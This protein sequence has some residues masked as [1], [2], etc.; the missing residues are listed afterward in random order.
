MTE[1]IAHKRRGLRSRPFDGEG[2]ATAP[3]KLVEGGRI[4]GWLMDS[5]SAR[6]LGKAPT[7]HASRGHGGAP[8][9]SASSRESSADPVDAAL[10]RLRL[11]EREALARWDFA[12]Q[13]PAGLPSFSGVPRPARHP[14]QA[15][16]AEVGPWPSRTP[17]S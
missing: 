10:S 4:T 17:S 12:K 15:V 5:A 14:G 2:L 3:R 16:P 1:S 11:I 6:Q 7:G 9:V 13:A 8:G